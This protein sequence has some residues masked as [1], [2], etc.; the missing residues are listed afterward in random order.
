MR[1]QDGLGGARAGG[2]RR[3]AWRFFP[4][5]IGAS[6][7]LVMV[8]NFGMI[9]AALHTFPGKAGSDGFDLSNHYDA[10]LDSVARQAA[11]GWKLEAA[12]DAERRPWLSL[13]DKDGRALAGAH[14]E[15]TAERPLGATNTT[16]IAFREQAPGR[17]VAETPLNLPG[18]WDLSLVTDAGGHEV[19][20]TRRII[21]R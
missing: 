19:I 3:S 5:A 14:V 1:L 2:P 12:A 7:G 15:A 21:V 9:Y 17:Y 13:V 18:Q 10:V 4:W 8:V 20:T 6:L 11:L 16:H